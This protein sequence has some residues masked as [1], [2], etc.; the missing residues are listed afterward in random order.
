MS[1]EGLPV[2]NVVGT[3]V[4]LGARSVQDAANSASSSQ[5]ADS[6]AASADAAWKF[7]RVAQGAAGDSAAAVSEAE[8]A[9][10][11][12]AEAAKNAATS[13]NIFPPPAQAVIDAGTI[14]LN[15]LFNVGVPAGSTP[16]RL[17]DQYKNVGGV[18]TP[19]GQTVVSGE[20][21]GDAVSNIN[22][23]VKSNTAKVDFAVVN[24]RGQP[25][26][27]ITDGE[28]T[29][30]AF[31]VLKFDDGDLFL[32]DQFGRSVEIARK[33]NG[34]NIESNGDISTSSFGVASSNTELEGV[35]YADQFGRCKEI[36]TPSNPDQ[37]TWLAE[38][39]AAMEVI[40]AQSRYAVETGRSNVVTL[41]ANLIHF[42][43]YGQSLQNGTEGTP[44]MS[45]T[46]SFDNL[47][48]GQSVMPASPIA[49]AFTPRGGATLN[50]LIATCA[51]ASGNVLTPEQ[52][53]ALAP[54]TIAYG[55]TPGESAINS[56]RRSF[57]DYIIQ[58]TDPNRKFVASAAGVGGRTA[59]QLSKGASPNLYQRY[60][61]AMSG[62][63]TIASGESKSYQVG[64]FI[65]IQGE[66]DYP[67]N[68]KDVYKATTN[69]ILS[70][71]QADRIMPPGETRASGIFMVQ[72]GASFTVD[73]HDM[74]VG[75]AQIEI[76]NERDDVYLVGGYYPYTDKNGHLDSNGYRW[77]GE[78]IAEIMFK[79]V[80]LREDWK[81]IQP[82]KAVYRNTDALIA[83]HVPAPPLQV[84]DPYVIN[85][86][87]SFTDLGFTALDRVSGV[88]TP[89]SINRVE[90]IGLST[91]YLSLARA[92]VGEL[93]IRY[94][95]K[96]YHNGNGMICDS[97]NG[98]SLNKYTY[99]PDSG[100]YASANIPALVDK[101]YD[102]RNW[103]VAYQITAEEV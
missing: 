38:Q 51:D 69:S 47:M 48:F 6:A 8:A 91:I 101:N 13:A 102:L 4:D 79:V 19:T 97:S 72:T 73:T 18:A 87:T 43:L 5:N 21:L 7:S 17:A 76:S 92:P 46:Q 26:V 62:V 89:I 37:Q 29:T 70:N 54:G 32:T 27:D 95:D 39:T 22:N 90:I 30:T 61:D 36:A 82:L 50:P 64:G 99:M 3:S 98:L 81:P 45:I 60:L 1:S 75:M 16:P 58:S 11:I 14:P 94:A 28:L 49:P 93:I 68:T 56:L 57:L 84:A 65:Y 25:S 63:N 85:T 67:S 52:V 88:D 71:M 74:A 23:L 2:N 40:G 33:N 86:A 34:L 35:F 80:V 100:M 9:A 53:A 20:A 55:E 59:A 78:K 66:N 15:A 24:E 96:T 12:A 10:A 77:F 83:K 44:A 103:S 31:R 42:I 41:L